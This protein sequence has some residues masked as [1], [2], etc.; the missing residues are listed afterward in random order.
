MC[1]QTTELAME[2]RGSRASALSSVLR[3]GLPTMDI[4]KLAPPLGLRWY[5]R[6]LLSAVFRASSI[7]LVMTGCTQRTRGAAAP[8]SG[9]TVLTDSLSYGLR[10]S[11]GHFRVDI[12]ATIA[13]RSKNV[14]YFDT[15]CGN[16]RLDKRIGGGWRQAYAMACPLESDLSILVALAPGESQWHTY[17]VWANRSDGNP[18]FEVDTIPGVYRIVYRI[19]SGAD[20]E[21][22]QLLPEDERASNQFTLH[23]QCPARCR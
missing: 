7:L 4:A 19:Y 9:P 2:E 15:S 22:S 5:P 17:R 16:G 13:N 14:I 6:A 3:V 1:S 18:R 20:A 10:D 21:R 11:A 12:G 23:Y 8:E